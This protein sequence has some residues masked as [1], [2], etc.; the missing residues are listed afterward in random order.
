MAASRIS[1][2]LR[3]A[4][5]L[6]LGAWLTA[7]SSAVQAQARPGTSTSSQVNRG[8]P[9][10][11]FTVTPVD[12]FRRLLD[13]DPAGREKLL[14]GKKP[15]QRKVLLNS[16][17]IYASLSP[18]EREL[19]LRTM[20][21]RFHL[22]SLL[23]VAPSNR[24]ARLNLVPERDQPLVKARL[25]LWDQL[26]AGAQKELLDNEKMMRLMESVPS[27]IP[28]REIPL[29]PSASNQ[30]RQAEQQLTRWEDLPE[31]ARARIRGNFA[32]I[33]ELTTAEK[34]GL[35]Q[36]LPLRP[37]E[38]ELMERTL[39]QF[40]RLSPGQR[41]LCIRNFE[42]LAALPPAERRQFLASAQE[43]ERMRPED[44][45]AWRRMVSRVPQLPPV[46]GRPSRPPLPPP[47]VRPAQGAAVART[48]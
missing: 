35:L 22:N 11:P 9:P 48:N 6:G 10:L 17:R 15:A 40:G 8:A 3:L 38:R 26:S 29:P 43:W 12:Y 19:R 46:P 23:R 41:D 18:E 27:G 30:V 44:R 36:P 16:L 1:N 14:A 32:R 34:A 42:K 45:A 4:A 24:L 47:T 25:A 37:E 7:G 31:T 5:C 2:L 20:E 13:A 28:R 21:L 33:F 39:A